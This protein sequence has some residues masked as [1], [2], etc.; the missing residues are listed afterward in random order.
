MTDVDMAPAAEQ[1]TTRGPQPP[2]AAAAATDSSA[3]EHERDRLQN[4]LAQLERS[5]GEL[6][7]ELD[8]Q[9]A[10]GLPLDRDYKEALEDNLVVVAKY[11]ARVAALEEEIRRVKSGAAEGEGGGGGVFGQ[12]RDVGGLGVGVGGQEQQPP[13]QQ[14]GGAGGAAAAAGAAGGGGGG[15]GTNEGV[16]V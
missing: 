14:T 16:W 8:A 11:R 1:P 2:A 12:P 7:R 15:G 10:Q 3:L 5:N 13:Q 4:A 9:R 6:R